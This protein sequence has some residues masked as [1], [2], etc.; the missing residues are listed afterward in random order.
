MIILPDNSVAVAARIDKWPF[1]QVTR[2]VLLLRA[3]DRIIAVELTTDAGVLGS[4]R[5]TL[6]AHRMPSADLA[7]LVPATVDGRPWPVERAL[8]KFTEIADALPTTDAARRALAI[9]HLIV[10]LTEPPLLDG[11]EPPPATNAEPPDT[12][13]AGD[14]NRARDCGGCGIARISLVTAAALAV[15]Y[16]LPWLYTWLWGNP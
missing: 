15:F 11:P 9:A 8:R 3:N 6:D 10:D 4:T 14:N 13:A 7:D 2:S 12:T 1:D 16:A 5:L